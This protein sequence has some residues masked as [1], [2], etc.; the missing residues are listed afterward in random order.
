MN[1]E[2][3]YGFGPKIVRQEETEKKALTMPIPGNLA[4]VDRLQII[5]GYIASEPRHMYRIRFISII[6]GISELDAA[7]FLLGCMRKSA[8]AMVDFSLEDI[9]KLS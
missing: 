3:D 2:N 5:M 4:E 7:F 9:Q 1:E 8:L 6:K